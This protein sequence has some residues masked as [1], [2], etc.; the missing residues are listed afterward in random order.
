MRFLSEFFIA[1]I[2]PLA[3]LFFFQFQIIFFES[4]PKLLRI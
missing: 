4:T 1:H 3:T 2:L